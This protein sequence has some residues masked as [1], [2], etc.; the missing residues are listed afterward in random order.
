MD[1]KSHDDRQEQLEKQLRMAKQIRMLEHDTGMM[2]AIV[3]VSLWLLIAT[4]VIIYAI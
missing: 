2:Q 1:T 4:V 3:F